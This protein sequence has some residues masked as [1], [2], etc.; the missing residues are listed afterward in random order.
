MSIL[1]YLDSPSTYVS[2]VEKV[3]QRL[4]LV[5][6]TFNTKEQYQARTREAIIRDSVYTL[7]L[8]EAQGYASRGATAKFSWLLLS[9]DTRRVVPLNLS[10]N[11]R[12]RSDVS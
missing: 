5:R 11:P 6:V 9:P 12:S 3:E 4:Q 7:S 8:L 1:D 10:D 2:L